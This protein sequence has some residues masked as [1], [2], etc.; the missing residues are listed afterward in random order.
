[1][2]TNDV[3]H[4]PTVVEA[5]SFHDA[6]YQ[7]SALTDTDIKLIV[8]APQDKASLRSENYNVNTND[9]LNVF[10]DVCQRI[11]IHLKNNA[12][13]NSDDDYRK[14]MKEWRWNWTQWA[15][16]TLTEK[17]YYATDDGGMRVIMP[18][19]VG[20]TEFTITWETDGIPEVDLSYSKYELEK[21][22]GHAIQINQ[23]S[24]KGF[25][26]LGPLIYAGLPLDK[27]SNK[28]AIPKLLWNMQCLFAIN[29]VIAERMSKL[30]VGKS[31]VKR[32]FQPVHYKNSESRYNR[33]SKYSGFD[34]SSTEDIKRLLTL[35]N[36]S[37]SLGK[38]YPNIVNFLEEYDTMI[39][40][41]SMQ[42][43]LN[44]QIKMHELLDEALTKLFPN[45]HHPTG[46]QTS[47]AQRKCQHNM[48][49]LFMGRKK[50]EFFIEIAESNEFASVQ[51]KLKWPLYTL[52]MMYLL[53][54]AK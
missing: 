30:H 13:N 45:E 4:K 20:L 49:D 36:E 51:S 22:W 14:L 10:P 50:A 21:M 46:Q 15:T 28:I 24:E 41:R 40:S 42:A 43:Y 48:Y 32:F 35:F 37:T 34:K 54:C 2:F 3:H 23:P 9:F 19:N 25:V 33:Q 16:D 7:L 11:T 1:M 39:D 18:T 6:R 52:G 44:F 29:D 17:V 38:K 27:N 8:H 12:K 26:K 31:E 47:E 5:N 53:A